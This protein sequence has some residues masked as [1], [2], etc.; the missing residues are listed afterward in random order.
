M[1]VNAVRGLINVLCTQLTYALTH[2]VE[3][4]WEEHFG[5]DPA[6]SPYRG[7]R[8][9]F[10]QNLIS[11][12]QFRFSEGQWVDSNLT[13]DWIEASSCSC[14]RVFSFMSQSDFGQSTERMNESLWVRCNGDD[15]EDWCPTS[16][17]KSLRDTPFRPKK[18]KL[19]GN[20]GVEAE[21]AS[22][23]LFEAY[24][25]LPVTVSIQG[26]FLEYV[27]KSEHKRRET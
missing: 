13:E 1:R 2:V 26:G 22:L 15:V 5:L 27:L 9:R 11:D 3:G 23:L 20:K 16:V 21:D 6:I 14:K 17:F 25:D 18:R 12:L 24:K 10:L 19:E 8:I 4:G 7:S